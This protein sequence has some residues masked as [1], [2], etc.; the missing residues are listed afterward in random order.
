MGE[1]LGDDRELYFLLWGCYYVFSYKEFRLMDKLND[2]LLD[3]VRSGIRPEVLNAN[4]YAIE[5]GLGQVNPLGY[6]LRFETKSYGY[7]I[8][9]PDGDIVHLYVL[10]RYGEIDAVDTLEDIVDLF[11]ERYWVKEF[12]NVLWMDLAVNLGKV[13]A[14]TVTRYE[15]I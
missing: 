6:D 7:L 2:I 10:G 9:I 1:K 15:R 8:S 4:D 11:V 12:G 5:L 14:T 3:I 13:K